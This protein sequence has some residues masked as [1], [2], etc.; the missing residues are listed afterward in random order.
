V[1]PATKEDVM[2]PKHA[3]VMAMLALWTASG[4]AEGIL[5]CDAGNFSAPP[6]QIL[7]VDMDGGNPRVFIDEGLA[8]PQDI[9]FLENPAVVLVSNL[10]SGTINRHDV[11]SGEL[12][13]AFA[14]GLAGP[15]RMAIGPDNLL[16]VLQWSGNG[17]VLRFAQ[18][19]TPLGEF[20]PVGV[21]QA[22]GLDW[23][24]EGRLYVSSYSLDHV[25]RFDTG[26]GD[27]GL[28]VS[29]GLAGPTNI[30]F[31]GE[32]DLLVADYDGGAVKRFSAEGDYEGVYI[33]GLGQ[34][35][36]VAHLPDGS[37]LIG[38]G[39]TH[40]V[41]RFGSDGTWLED[42]VPAGS[43]NLLTPNAV[44]LRGNDVSVAGP[45]VAEGIPA[46]LVLDPVHP[47][48]FNPVATLTFRLPAADRTR[49]EVYDITGAK[50][51]EL[52]GGMLPAGEH[53]RVLDGTGL[54]A[55]VYICRITSGSFSATRKLAL[56]K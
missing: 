24:A 45:P 16:Y 26:G 20:S 19:G 12:L 14:T 9:L 40:S 15:T 46:G 36:G 47:N 2:G 52:P 54:P 25:R 39:A 23:D 43:G 3:T 51:L 30:W 37:L 33:G 21:S 8:W 13:G 50:V 17:R 35:E 22:I 34:C 31:D 44:V 38:N 7:E 42:L 48:P 41:K 32:G 27:L 49:I 5:V 10:N 18:D 53:V 29:S 55:G 28:F 4:R 6:W 1:Y 11:T 56:V